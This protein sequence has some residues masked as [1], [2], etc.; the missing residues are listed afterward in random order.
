MYLEKRLRDFWV[1]LKY[2]QIINKIII[3]HI[4]SNQMWREY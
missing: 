4:L 1:R 2:Q 3:S